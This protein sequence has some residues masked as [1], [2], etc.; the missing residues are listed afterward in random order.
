MEVLKEDHKQEQIQT[1]STTTKIKKNNLAQIE[2]PLG[3]LV[4]TQSTIKD[5]EEELKSP[6]SAGVIDFKQFAKNLRRFS[7]DFLGVSSSNLFYK[8]WKSEINC[9]ISKKELLSLINVAEELV[10]SGNKLYVD[11]EKASN[12]FYRNNY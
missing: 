7:K 11:L 6:G 9:N 3:Q 8:E 2:E 10:D 1:P 12:D 4:V 5:K